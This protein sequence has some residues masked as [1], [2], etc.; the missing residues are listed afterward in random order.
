[1][2]K[3][4][5]EFTTGRQTFVVKGGQIV[6]GT[7]DKKGIKGAADLRITDADLDRHYDL[8]RRQYFMNRK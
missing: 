8:V 1:V 7:A 6:E 2:P 5:K 4:H 3:D